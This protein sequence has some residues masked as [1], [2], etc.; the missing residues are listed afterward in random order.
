MPLPLKSG[1]RPCPSGSPRPAAGNEAPARSLR[2]AF[3]LI[4]LLVVI[5]IIAILAGL[6][7]P[8]L[9]RAKVKSLTTRCLSNERQVGV[10]LALYT[11]D[12]VDAFPFSGRDWPQMP[13]VDVLR[14]FNPYI[15]TNAR[16]FYHCPADR[17]PAW[18][19]QW[20]KDNPGFGVT[21]NQ[22][23]FP[24]SY[25]YY[26]Q[27]YHDD[28]FSPV[29]K[30]RKATEVRSPSKKAVLSCFAELVRGNLFDDNLAHGR[31][32]WPLLFVDSHSE[33]VKTNRLNQTKPYG[34]YNLDWTVGGLA[35]GEDLK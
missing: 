12:N 7:L 34:P 10:T 11:A 19:H 8:A 35:T 26:H 16:A 5:A 33:F 21:T 14:L 4:E 17:P 23:L 28:S 24:L 29:L 6:L 9:S 1:V 2:G 20:T 31:G 18:S 25:Y 13:L 22:L 27:F 32:G 30:V 3:T 15:S